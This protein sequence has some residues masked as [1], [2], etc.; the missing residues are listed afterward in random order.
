MEPLEDEFS[1]IISKARR[2][3]GMSVAAISELSNVPE[4]IIREMEAG[5]HR[6]SQEEAVAIGRVLHI[7][8]EKLYRIARGLWYPVQAEI[9]KTYVELIEGFIGTY[10]AKAYI[11]IDPMSKEAVAFDTANNSKG[12][13]SILKRRDA[14][15]KYLFLTHTHFDHVG[16]AI[17]IFHA[18]G[19]GIG[20]PEGEESISLEDAIKR[21]LFIVKDSSEY[22]VGSYRIKALFTPGH[23]PGSTSYMVDKYLFPGD[24]IFAGSVGRAYSPEGYV[25]ILRSVREKI[26]T[27]NDNIII[28]PGHGPPTTVGEEKKNNPFI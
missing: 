18:T 26:L 12:I 9:D 20:V 11:F 8:G 22:P 13:L 2:G 19:A 7:N 3:L 25:L 10:K 1:H 15:L 5:K 23:T 28:C 16:G 24:T 21:G 4:S 6:P 27:L 17:E 14:K